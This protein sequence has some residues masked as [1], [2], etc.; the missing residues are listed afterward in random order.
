MP[1]LEGRLE[2]EDRD[3]HL[4]LLPLL[5]DAGDVPEELHEHLGGG[6]VPPRLAGLHLLHPLDGAQLVSGAHRAIQPG[7]RLRMCGTVNY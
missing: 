4:H 7:A 2:V 3:G 1:H 5:V 6:P